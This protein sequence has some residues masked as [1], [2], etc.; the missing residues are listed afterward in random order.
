MR[1]LGTAGL[2]TGS[3]TP[4]D[5]HM[6]HSGPGGFSRLGMR[7]KVLFEGR[8][9]NEDV[10]LPGLPGATGPATCCLSALARP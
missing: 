1:Q 7:P 5:D 9:T 4:A 3:A 10:S 8:L 6:R 2:G